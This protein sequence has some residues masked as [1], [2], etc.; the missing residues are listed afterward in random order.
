M[1]VPSEIE[2]WAQYNADEWL[3]RIGKAIVDAHRS[4]GG[5]A[6]LLRAEAGTLPVMDTI[7]IGDGE[8][9]FADAK[10]K[11]SS[12][13]WRIGWIEQHGIDERN[14]DGYVHQ[15][16]EAGV[17]GFIILSE[18]R[19]EIAPNQYEDSNKLLIY[20]LSEDIK[21]FRRVK[22]KDMNTPYGKNGMVY[23]DRDAFIVEEDLDEETE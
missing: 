21:G 23:W 5:N 17:P 22:R 18:K 1:Y 7:A 16:K 10:G 11:T 2:H 8:V 14:W 9:W 19:R 15:C 6:A 13:F 12:T 4:G 20:P 3:K